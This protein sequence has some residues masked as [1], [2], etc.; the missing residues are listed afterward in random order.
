MGRLLQLEGIASGIWVLVLLTSSELLL[1]RMNT[2]CVCVSAF[3]RVRE[4]E[5]SND[6]KGK[7][8]VCV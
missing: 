8:W 5:E 2:R 1:Q 4:C 3:E 6:E 7:L